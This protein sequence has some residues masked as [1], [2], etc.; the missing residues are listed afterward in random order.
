MA[1]G[2]HGMPNM[3]GN[4]GQLLQ[5]AQ[6]MQH[7][8]ERVQEEIKNSTVD[9]S[10]G[11]GVVSLVLGGD[12][13]IKSITIDPKAVDSE[14]IEM[15]QDLIIAACNE[16]QRKLEELSTTKMNQVTDGVKMPF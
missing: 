1:K 15:L 13:Q 16:A 4:M 7:D 6:K 12:H 5:Q 8:V 9:A 2:F 3:G 11:G 14:D 10:S